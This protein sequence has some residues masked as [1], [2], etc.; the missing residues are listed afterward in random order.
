MQTAHSPFGLVITVGSKWDYNRDLCHSDH[1][2]GL[3]VKE[4]DY[5]DGAVIVRFEE[6]MAYE[7]YGLGYFNGKVFKPSQSS[8]EPS[9]PVRSAEEV[10]EKVFSS[11]F[12]SE[13]TAIRDGY[14][15][16]FLEEMESYAS[17]FKGAKPIFYYTKPENVVGTWTKISKE[18]DKDSKDNSGE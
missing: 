1:T 11:A 8:Q 15:E 13:P 12:E 16:R 9:Q 5:N 17:Q 6:K 2:Q 7:G 18:E 3:T 4:I 14:K 10:F